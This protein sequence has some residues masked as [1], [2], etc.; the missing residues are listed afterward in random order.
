MKT[1]SELS[2]V[3]LHACGYACKTEKKRIGSETERA[4]APK[5]IIYMTIHFPYV[6]NKQKK[7]I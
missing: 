5:H 4:L 2:S 7:K 1:K 3:F 6:N